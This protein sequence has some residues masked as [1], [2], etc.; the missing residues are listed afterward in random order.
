MLNKKSLEAYRFAI[1]FCKIN[2]INR[3]IAMPAL[4]YWIMI[5]KK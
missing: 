1:L 2:K 3:Q 4:H 5:V